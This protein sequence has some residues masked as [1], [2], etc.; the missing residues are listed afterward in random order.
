MARKRQLKADY[1]L[2]Q[3]IKREEKRIRLEMEKAMEVMQFNANRLQNI[4]PILRPP[5]SPVYVPDKMASDASGPSHSEQD[6]VNEAMTEENQI[7]EPDN[8][9]IVN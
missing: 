2:V 9:Q 5:G 7:N 6:C 4:D 3:E 1:K 8:T